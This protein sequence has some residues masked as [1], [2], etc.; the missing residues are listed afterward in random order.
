M[1]PLY[2]TDQFGRFLRESPMKVFV[3]SDR[4]VYY[5]H[6]GVLSSCKLST[7]DICINGSWKDAGEGTIDWTDSDSQTIECVLRYLY[8]G[9]Y[10][11]VEEAPT[12]SEGIHLEQSQE[13]PLPA[14]KL[15]W[16]FQARLPEQ[17]SP[18]R[19]LTPIP[20]CLKAG[21]PTESMRTVAGL[22]A[23]K[24]F[25]DRGHNAGPSVFVHAKVYSFAHRY[26]FSELEKLA[27]QRLTQI[28]HLAPCEQTSLF[29]GL[30]DAI[31]HIYG[32]TPGPEIQENPARKL[33]SQYVA[34]NYT[35]LSGEK[36]DKLVSEGGEFMIDVSNKLTRKIN[37]LTAETKDKEAQ[38]QKLREKNKKEYEIPL[39]IPEL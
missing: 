7:A 26:F 12:S 36:L 27:L 10:Y 33:L 15:S 16:S 29:P 25:K 3:G 1:S 8:T 18:R 23:K 5:V 30:A 20:K 39:K 9:D 19:P 17:I 24:N 21:L 31:R 22:V 34:I 38:L 13:E 2:L 37:F 4:A 28:L 35:N 11:A 32:T 14:N 6:P